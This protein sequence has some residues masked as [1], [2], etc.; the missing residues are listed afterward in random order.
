MAQLSFLNV[1]IISLLLSVSSAPI[2]GQ[3]SQVHNH[4]LAETLLAQADSSSSRELRDGKHEKTGK[5]APPNDP[6]F[7]Q[8][9]IYGD[10]A[11]RAENTSPRETSL[12]LRLEKGDSVVFIGNTLFDRDRLFG[13][14]ES[15]IHQTH[16]EKELRI[17]ILAWAADE[18]DLQPRPDNFGDLD[19]HLTA[20]QADVIFAAFGYNESF[21]GIEAL[22]AF[23]ERLRGFIQRTVSRAYNGST[24]PRVRNSFWS[25]R[26]PMRMSRASRLQT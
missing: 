13:Y 17:R 24:D 12:P 5:K 22:P 18:V 11:P 9:A 7:A 19:Q 23:R 6:E 2:S 25:R 16:P 3:G 14:F 21:A 15:L 4:A 10:S 1:S 8:Y 20:Q 26:S